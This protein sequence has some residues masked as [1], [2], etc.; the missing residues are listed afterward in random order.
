MHLIKALGQSYSRRVTHWLMS[1]RLSTYKNECLA[2][3]LAVD[4]WY[5]YLQHSE[6]VIKTD[7]KSLIHLDDQR[8]IT[9]WQHKALTKLLGLSYK[10]VYKQGKDNWVAD[11]LSRTNH[12]TYHEIAIVSVVTSP[13]VQ[14]LLA[15]YTQDP[16]TSKL[17]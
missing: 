13:W 1:A 10:I 9:P 14:T 6:F 2:I 8:L 12:A 7:H 11:A 15:T 5:S 16:D 4:H 17:L 3:L